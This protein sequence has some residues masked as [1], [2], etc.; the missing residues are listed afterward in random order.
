[1]KDLVVLKDNTDYQIDKQLF[2]PNRF[3]RCI[4][5]K[6]GYIIYGEFFTKKIA[7]QIFEEVNLRIG[8]Q[9]KVVGLLG[10]FS[11]RLSKTAFSKL[12]DIHTYGSG[13]RKL[14]TI[15][16]QG[17]DDQNNRIIYGFYPMQGNKKEIIDE[18]YQMYI[19]TV[20]GD[21]EHLDCGDIQFGNCGIPL[22]YGKLRVV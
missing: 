12:A 14:N 11:E 1:M 4:E 22:Q 7:E 5:T 19:D 13:K 2:K 6:R 8:K 10:K 20:N 18:C 9:F 3:Y 17:R 21:M 16:F 15:F